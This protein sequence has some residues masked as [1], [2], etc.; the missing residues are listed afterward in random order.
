MPPRKRNRTTFEN[1]CFFIKGITKASLYLP[2]SYLR[3]TLSFRKTTAC[4]TEAAIQ[5]QSDKLNGLKVK[6]YFDKER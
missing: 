2:D 4:A 6:R 3:S 1:I 5:W